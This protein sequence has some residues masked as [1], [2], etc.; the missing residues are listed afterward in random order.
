VL[1]RLGSPRTHRGTTTAGAEY[2]HLV[3]IERARLSL[4]D[5]LALLGEHTCTLSPPGKG[6]DCFRTWQAL[7]VGTVPLVVRDERFDLRLIDGTGPEA[8]PPPQEL[9]PAALEELLGQLSAPPPHVAARLEMAHW[10]RTWHGH[11]GS[12]ADG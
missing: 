3:R 7:A 11:L 2:A 9:T 12:E 10:R 4:E 1:T 8:L 5:F 6:Y